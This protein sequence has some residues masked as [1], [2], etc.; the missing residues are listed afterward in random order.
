MIDRIAI[1]GVGLIGGSLA[2]V[3]RREKAC[4]EIVGYGHDELQLKEA[5]ELGVIDEYFQDPAEAVINTD[6]IVLATPLATMESLM[7]SI[8]DSID[9]DAVV[10]DVGSSKG[11]VVDAA[12]KVLD[13]E[14]LTRFVPGHPIA[15]TEKSGVK[16]SFA[17][18][19]E[20][21][22][23]ILTPVSE[24]GQSSIKLV[25]QMWE[26]AGAN[27]IVMDVSHHDEVLAATSHLP[28]MLAYALVDCLAAMQDREEIFKYAAGG[29]TDFTRIASSSPQMWHD[30]CFSNRD[31]LLKMLDRFD[32]HIVQIKEAIRHG[33]S[34]RLLE[35]FTRAKTS[36]DEFS[37]RKTINNAE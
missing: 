35:I 19:F 15:G 13:A 30:V 26:A 6:M 16:A 20:D 25:R 1:L 2:R 24:T 22:S 7:I 36:R 32:T 28:H 10:T 33:D 9:A 17:E 4:G 18:L 11:G 12:K 3:L 27:V 37:R 5:V 23:V 21:H 14:Q 34:Q 29:F 31:E 8:K